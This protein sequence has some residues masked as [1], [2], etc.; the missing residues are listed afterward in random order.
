M[1]GFVIGTLSLIGLIKVWRWGRYGRHGYGGPR[2]WMLRRLF[3]HLDTTPGQEKVIASA[4]EDAE[5]KL[6]A[7]RE[8]LFKSR[9]AFAKAVSGEHFDGAAVDA[10]FDTQQAAVDELKKSVREGLGAI[11]EA[12]NPQQRARLGEL[13]EYGPGRMHGGCGYGR[14]HHGY[15][16]GGG[17]AST[18]NL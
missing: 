17:P 18:V 16:H 15:R 14:F 4:L 8:E 1:F 5:R 10:A 11:H 7:A 6:W 13:L 2:R 3:Q 12:L 9:G